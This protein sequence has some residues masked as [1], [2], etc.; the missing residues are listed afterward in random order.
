MAPPKGEAIFVCEY[1]PVELVAPHAPGALYPA[2]SA[3]FALITTGS[4][5]RA[6]MRIVPPQAVQA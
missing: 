1:V 5:M 6:T 2:G 3:R 4:K